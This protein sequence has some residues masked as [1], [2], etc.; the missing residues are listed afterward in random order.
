[1]RILIRASLLGGLFF[2]EPKVALIAT[3]GVSSGYIIR[4]WRRRK[5]GNKK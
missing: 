1:M 5:L 3:A 2:L 4:N